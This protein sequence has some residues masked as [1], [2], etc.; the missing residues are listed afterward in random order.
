MHYDN[1]Y[2]LRQS[3]GAQTWMTP[4]W[5]SVLFECFRVLIAFCTR[6]HGCFCISV[7]RCLL[8]VSYRTSG[9]FKNLLQ[10]SSFSKINHSDSSNLLQDM[11]HLY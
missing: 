10:D 9:S 11:L 8:P 4:W 2:N 5:R 1:G 7:H 3:D 6:I